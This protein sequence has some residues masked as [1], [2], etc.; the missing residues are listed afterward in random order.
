MESNNKT[1]YELLEIR[2]NASEQEIIRAYRRLALKW[3][4][5]KNLH[6]L[7]EAER[8]FLDVAEAYQVLS[9]KEKRELYDTSLSLHKANLNST[10]TSR[11]NYGKSNKKPYGNRSNR[12]YTPRTGNYSR[13]CMHQSF[14][15]ETFEKSMYDYL[16]CKRAQSFYQNQNRSFKHSGAYRRET[17][18][19]TRQP[20]KTNFSGHEAVDLYDL[21]FMLKTKNFWI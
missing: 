15:N 9:N 21:F 3:H 12:S 6:N 19:A 1:Y 11:T 8:R 10:P 13:P 18:S 7:K 20:Y 4:P 2:Q 14:S 16:Y 17:N 5:D